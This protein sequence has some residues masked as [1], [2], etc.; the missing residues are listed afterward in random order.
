MNITETRSSDAGIE[1]GG[2]VV[3]NRVFFF[4]AIDPQWQRTPYIAPEGFPLRSVG[5]VEQD[6]RIIA[7]AAKGTWQAAAGHRL[8]ASFFGDPAVG[9]NGPQR[10]TAL[11]RTDTSGFSKLDQYG[12]HN[13]T[14]RYEGAVTPTW[15]LEASFARAK[16]SIVEIP[17][18]NQP[19]ITDNTV[20]P[21]V[22]SGGIGFYEVGNTRRELAISGEGHQRD[23]TIR[24]ARRSNTTTST[25]QTRSIGPGPTFTL[26]DGTQTAT[27]RKSDRRGSNV[28]PDFPRHPRA[29]PATSATRGSTTSTRSRRTPGTSAAGSRS[30]PGSATN[31]RR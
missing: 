31:V 19:S 7:Y 6:R 8:D 11:L 16:N 1:A 29:T 23:H 27:G 30:I 10:Y 13:Q 2:P 18:V 4:G 22:R 26:V 9:D 24:S 3:P 21:Q 5:A 14:V 17:S 15:L 25:T 12:G 20:T 28:R